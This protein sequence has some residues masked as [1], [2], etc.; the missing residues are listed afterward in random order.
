[1]GN[2]YQNESSLV[3]YSMF[4][5]VRSIPVS[6][7]FTKFFILLLTMIGLLSVISEFYYL[8]NLIYL[9][10]NVSERRRRQD[11]FYSDWYAIYR[12]HG[13]LSLFKSIKI[14]SIQTVAS[15]LWKLTFI[16]HLVIDFEWIGTVSHR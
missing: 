3:W 7:L 6:R 13:V 2:G 1:M 10:L 8:F 4:N 5:V 16:L 14:T 9:F 12:P 15:W 11:H